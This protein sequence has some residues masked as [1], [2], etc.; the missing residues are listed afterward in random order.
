MQQATLHPEKWVNKYANYL[1]NYTLM[2][3][4][5]REIAKDLI[6]E[7]FLSALNALKNFKGESSERTWLISIL[8]RKIIDYYRKTNSQKG[9]AEI[10]MELYGESQHG[11]WLEERVANQTEDAAEKELTNQELKMAIREC[12]EQLNDRQK[13]IFMMK[14]IDKIDTES[15]CKEFKITPSNLWVIIH[16]VRVILADCLEKKGYN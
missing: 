5:N 15:I 13:Q 9:Q 1:L 10:K 2:R 7:T 4:S 14:T 16:R 11:N 8:K 12:L 3:I 6:S